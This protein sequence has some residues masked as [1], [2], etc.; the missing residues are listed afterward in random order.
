MNADEI[1]MAEALKLAALAAQLGEVPVGALVVCEDKIVGRGFNRR[2]ILTCAVK[3]AEM[4]AIMEA[5]AF[6]GR[7]RLS[8]CTLYSTLEPCIMCAGALVQARLGKLVFGALDPKFGGVESLY[9]ILKDPRL[10]HRLPHTGGIGA[11]ESAK[12]MQNFFIMA[13]RRNSSRH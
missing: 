4:L 12:L 2:E 9:Q 7:W 3:H 5:S 11:A 8:D 13:R 10:N 1:Y 6:L